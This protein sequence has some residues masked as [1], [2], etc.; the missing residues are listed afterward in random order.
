MITGTLRRE[1]CVSGFDR[2]DD[3]Q[4]LSVNW[5]LVGLPDC[6]SSQPVHVKAQIDYLECRD[7]LD[8][9]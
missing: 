4:M 3:R 7:Q 9:S 5:A 2:F 1:L 8:T 6:G